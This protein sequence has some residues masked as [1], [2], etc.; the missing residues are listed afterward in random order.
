ML[1]ELGVRDLG[2]IDRLSVGLGPGM[3]VVAVDGKVMLMMNERRRQHFFRQLE[4]LGRER[5]ADD[6]WI[7]DEIGNF[8]QQAGIGVYRSADAPLK[9][10]I[11]GSLLFQYSAMLKLLGS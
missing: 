4:K 7:L 2:V 1:L 11:F 6:G 8:I 5:A 9:A 10:L 3:T